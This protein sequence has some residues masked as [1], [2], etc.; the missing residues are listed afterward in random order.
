MLY[1]G[2]LW[3]LGGYQTPRSTTYSN[4]IT[5]F[6]LS[7]D[8]NLTNPNWIDGGSIDSDVR[9]Q[10]SPSAAIDSDNGVFYIFGAYSQ[11]STVSLEPTNNGYNKVYS[12]SVGSNTG[13]SGLKTLTNNPGPNDPQWRFQHTLDYYKNGNQ[14]IMHGGRYFSSQSGQLT[15]S[16]S[17][18]SFDIASNSWTLISNG[19]PAVYYHN[20]LIYNNKLYIIGGTSDGITINGLDNAYILDL[21]TKTWTTKKLSSPPSNPRVGMSLVLSGST[22]AIFGGYVNLSGAFTSDFF[23]GYTLNL[24][25][26]EWITPNKNSDIQNAAQ[27]AYMCAVAT[28]QNNYLITQGEVS[29]NTIGTTVADSLSSSAQL[30]NYNG[31]TLISNNI[32]IVLPSTQNLVNG[33]IGIIL[34]AVLIP[35]AFI[36]ITWL[37]CYCY[38]KSQAGKSIAYTVNEPVWTDPY[39]KSNNNSSYLNATATNKGTDLTLENDRQIDY[40]DPMNLDT[41]L[42]ANPDTVLSAS[43]SQMNILPVNGRRSYYE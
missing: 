39:E 10:Y 38:K 19:G 9:F 1:N 31:W 12:Y 5:S 8:F 30:W 2:V 34:M 24:D 25:K 6:S 18:Y 22:A 13:S 3:Y 14:L 42:F 26:L 20:S 23:A 17:T 40:D 4:K 21:N 41:D 35:L 27:R 16:N 11:S 28:P 33:K 29:S 43:Q 15:T 7:T 36:F 37:T 32:P